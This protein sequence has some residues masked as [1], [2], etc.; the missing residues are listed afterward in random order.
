MK[1]KEIDNS[2]KESNITDSYTTSFNQPETDFLLNT[3]NIQHGSWNYSENISNSNN[4]QNKINHETI[5][6]TF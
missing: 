4:D 2:E 1:N 5:N 6:F 3:N